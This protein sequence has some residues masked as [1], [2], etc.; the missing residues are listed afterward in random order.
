ML[1]RSYVPCQTIPGNLC[2]FVHAGYPT[3]FTMDE[4][5]S[6]D[7]KAAILRWRT[8]INKHVHCECKIFDDAVV[9]WMLNPGTT[10]YV[11]TVFYY[12]YLAITSIG[13]AY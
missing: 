12:I 10:E 1:S 4:N 7:Y 5:F 6:L 9:L 8:A 11:N 2:V 3:I 13:C